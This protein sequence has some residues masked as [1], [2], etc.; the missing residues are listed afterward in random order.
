MTLSGSTWSGK[1]QVTAN[2]TDGAKYSFTLT[3]RNT[4]NPF[5]LK[6]DTGSTRI[7]YTVSLNSFT[8]GGGS[9][10]LGNQLAYG[11]TFTSGTASSQTL[12]GGGVNSTIEFLF[13]TGTPVGTLT[14]DTYKDTVDVILTY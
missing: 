8:A 1:G 3:S 4:T 2:C 6:P 10:S 11:N 12:V 13:T 7:P 9:A 5:N 14:A